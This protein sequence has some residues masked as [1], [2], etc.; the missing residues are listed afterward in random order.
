MNSPSTPKPSKAAIAG[1][2]ADLANFPMQYMI[3]ALAQTG[4][5]KKINGKTYDFT[6]LGTAEQQ[7]QMSD[8]MAQTLLDI[9]RNYGSAYIQQRLADL[10]QSDPV[11]YAARKQLFDRILSD[12]KVN[13][14]RPLAES[15]QRDVNSM[16]ETAGYLD[17][18]ALEQV[19]N[20]VRGRQVARG[21]YLGSAPAAEESSSVVEA[22]DNLRRQ[23][24]SKAEQYLASGVSPEDVT[25]RRIQQSLANLGAFANAE[26]PE[27]QFGSLAG[28]GRGAAPFS[29]AGFQQPAE[30][31]PNAAV[32]GM[33]FANTIYADQSRFDASQANPWLTGLDMGINALTAYGNLG[34][35]SGFK[36]GPAPAG[37]TT[38]SNYS[39]APKQSY[40]GQ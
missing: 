23:E 12:S 38:V 8:K 15:L 40:W 25:Y 10:Q 5:V 39:F 9:Q 11:G 20:Q 1:M 22:S 17:K 31:N 32:E 33:N 30:I 35:F 27:N 6:G 26:S 29:A 34:G 14:D 21:I 13:P 36:P 37:T 2:N 16:L 19:Q 7:G 24:Q 28:A 18:Q 3:N 4:G